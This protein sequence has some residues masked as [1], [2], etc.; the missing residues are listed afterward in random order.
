MS[1]VAAF[2]AKHW[3]WFAA[4]AFI[5]AV[6]IGFRIVETQRDEWIAKE[7]AARVQRDQIKAQLAVS[8]ASVGA[9]QGKVDEQNAAITQLGA[10]SEARLLEGRALILGEVRKGAAAIQAASKLASAP[11]TG[12]DQSKTSD[13]LLAM[14][15]NL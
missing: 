11:K 6:F 8:N 3:K 13:A 10:D 12:G 1:V 9:L 5:M 2:V 15:N 14:R 4:G 7:E